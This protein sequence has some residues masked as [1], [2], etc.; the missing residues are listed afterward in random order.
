TNVLDKAA[1]Y[2]QGWEQA[3]VDGGDKVCEENQ[4]L[5]GQKVDVI[6]EAKDN[7]YYYDALVAPVDPTAFVHEID[8]PVFLAG[9]FQDEQT[10]PFFFTL[11]DQFTSPPSTRLT[12]FNGVHIDGVAPHVLVEWKA[13]LDLYVAH[14]VP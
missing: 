12:V 4:L 5:H 1:P 13:F 7:P 8:V 11:L 2:G 6:Q 3:R 14:D 9:A 10:G